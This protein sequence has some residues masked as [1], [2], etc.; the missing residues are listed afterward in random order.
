MPFIDVRFE[1]GKVREV[2]E[3]AIKDGCLGIKGAFIPET[4]RV[5][6]IKGIPQALGIPTES[7][8][9]LQEE[10]FSSA[11]HLNLPLLYHINLSL[12]GDWIETM[13]KKFPRITI[14][15]PHLGYSLKRIKDLLQRF[16]HTYTDPS[17]L[18]D[19]LQKNNRR[20]LSFM[21]TCHTKI[22]SG[23]D[24]I[25]A[26]STEGILAY[27]HYFSHLSFPSQAKNNILRKNAY[28]FL[29]LIS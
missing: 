18:I 11:F 14:N 20:Y 6:N 9:R 5:L 17:Y 25:I 7:Y 28:H 4:D 12:Y 13:L 2:I 27:P 19:L 26:G 10:I 29:S 3:A 22:L 16:E 1:T 23:S 24:A 8:Y 21:E 15:I